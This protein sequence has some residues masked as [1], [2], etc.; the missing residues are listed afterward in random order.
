[1]NQSGSEGTAA[2]RITTGTGGNITQTNNPAWARFRK[3]SG[4]WLVLERSN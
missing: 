2:L 1:V 4:D 3:R